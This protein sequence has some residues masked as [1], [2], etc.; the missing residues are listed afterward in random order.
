MRCLVDVCGTKPVHGSSV[1]AGESSSQIPE[2]RQ[3]RDNSG[4]PVEQGHPG[5]ISL[6]S[7]QAPRH[8]QNSA[9][10]FATHAHD[11]GYLRPSFLQYPE[12]QD[13]N[14]RVRA[15]L[16][17]IIIIAGSRATFCLS[18]GVRSGAHYFWNCPGQIYK[19]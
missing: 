6:L 7:F 12:Q 19:Q 9:L 3:K 13:E 15:Q 5:V 14:D 10:R 1:G 8:W 17:S 4:A 16:R 18:G 2:W 11:G